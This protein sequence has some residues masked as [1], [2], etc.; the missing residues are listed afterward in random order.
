MKSLVVAILLLAGLVSG[1]TSGQ[2]IY[3]TG[4]YSVRHK[5]YMGLFNW[6]DG[7]NMDVWAPEAAGEFPVIY[8]ISGFTG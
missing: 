1:L 3:Q 4:P 5:L 2:D 8:F 7:H 6:G